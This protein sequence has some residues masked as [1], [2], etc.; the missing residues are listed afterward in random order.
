MKKK[1]LQ[2][3]SAIGLAV[4]MTVCT[5][6]ITFAEMEEVL[7]QGVFVDVFTS[8]SDGEEAAEI[9]D[10]SLD[11][12]VFEENNSELDAE[13][14]EDAVV[15][16]DGDSSAVSEVESEEIFTSGTEE[17]VDTSDFTY[18]LDAATGTATITGYTGTA[19]NIT[20]PAQIVSRG[21]TYRVEEIGDKAFYNN[22][23]IQSV[24][25]EEGI[26]TIG[27]FAFV[28]CT[29]LEEVIMCDSITTLN[30]YGAP[31]GPFGNCARLK[32]VKLSEGL[33]KIPEWC[34]KECRSLNQIV[35]PR[36]VESIE[37]GAFESCS[38]LS[39]V[40]FSMAKNLTVIDGEAFADCNLEYVVFPASFANFGFYDGSFVS[41][42]IRK[43][44]FRENFQ[45]CN[46]GYSVTVTDNNDSQSIVI[47]SKNISMNSPEFGSNAEIYGVSGT[48]VHEMAKNNGNS[49][50]PINAVSN[51]STDKVD[52]STVRLTWNAVS[53]VAR[54]KIYRA[55][56]ING[57][58]EELGTVSGTEY[59]DSSAKEDSPNYYKMCVT[60]IDCLGEVVDGLMSNV[61]NGDLTRVDIADVDI[62]EIT[63]I[64]YTGEEICP[65]FSASYNGQVL[66][67]GEDYTLSYSNN[68]EIGRAAIT[69]TGIND[70]KSE[71]IVNFDIIPM[72]KDIAKVTVDAVKDVEYTGKAITPDLT[73]KYEG[74]KLIKGEDYQLSYANN[75][76]VG[77]AKIT[78]TGINSYKGSKVVY[79]KIKNDIP[80]Q[81]V[82][83]SASVV[84]NKYVNLKWKTV[85]GATGYRLYRKSNG[86]SW[87]TVKTLSGTSFTDKGVKFGQKYTYTVKAYKKVNGKTY[88][89][90]YNKTG[91]TITV[92]LSAPTLSSAKASGYNAAAITWKKVSGATGYR[93]YRKVAGSGSYKSV[94]T[95]KNVS[96]FT[97]TKAPG[98]KTYTYTVRAYK[99][100]GSKTI[101][102][103]YSQ[104]GI[105]VKTKMQPRKITLS[106][107]KTYTKYDITGDGKNDKIVLKT[108]KT[109]SGLNLT[110]L[111]NGKQA[112]SYTQKD[113]LPKKYEVQLCT[114]S[115]TEEFV[116]IR[117]ESGENDRQIFHK[118]YK[119]TKGKL[120]SVFDVKK[121]LNIQSM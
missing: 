102:G 6:C 114:T 1:L 23:T 96:S 109:N 27:V 111:I 95:L 28:N 10:E 112:F 3:I 87:K 98:G 78:I 80:Q 24:S 51:L 82:I 71:R 39:N 22:N 65:K 52:N 106:T 117:Y 97:D 62:E 61:V 108:K 67:K 70:Y 113:Y 73:I 45:G 64:E 99:K 57:K 83:N 88:W 16:G 49:F 12:N 89:S 115:A 76:K 54:Y 94:A 33:S 55:E 34:F 69:I 63:A 85:P 26:K 38:S 17:N 79:F 2:K 19:A 90:T 77:Q 116:S 121:A 20:I 25:M 92:T 4:I 48:K 32:S 53:P 81:P 43:M 56:E 66:V 68:V 40:D 103:N 75:I 14:Q 104:A 72:R 5:P 44:V 58:Y 60:Y 35:I 84:S 100:S 29:Y 7:D 93:V 59:I 31:F 41:N 13:Q 18:T 30:D 107:N 120:K 91:K 21:I 110:I 46:Y 37:R 9:E 101:W 105:N 50:Y 86:S 36:N 42:P 74:A 47:Y 119:Y 118:M 11:M 8:D 15:F